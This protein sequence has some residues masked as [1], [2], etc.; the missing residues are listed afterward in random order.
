V[1]TATALAQ[2]VTGTEAERAIQA[3]EV[4]SF[5]IRGFHSGSRIWLGH[6][7][8]PQGYCRVMS[9]GE[10]AL[11]ELA[12]LASKALPYRQTGLVLRLQAAGDRLSDELD[13]EEALNDE[14]GMTYREYPCP[15]ETS[16]YAG[17]ARLLNPIV[18]RLPSCRERANAVRVS[19]AARRDV[20]QHCLHSPGRV[21]T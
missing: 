21:F 16:A 20:M 10:F 8:P 2:P 5:E 17:R 14:A 13:V 15:S 12:R 7:P 6:T 11:K 4:L 3:A 9:A 18:R 1:F 19:F